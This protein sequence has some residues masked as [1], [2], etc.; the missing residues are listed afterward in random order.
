MRTALDQERYYNKLRYCYE[1]KRCAR[2]PYKPA[3]GRRR[4][5]ILP[6]DMICHGG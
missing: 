1:K 5:L 3:P 6:N 2:G 4:L